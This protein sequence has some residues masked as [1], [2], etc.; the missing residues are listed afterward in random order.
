MGEGRTEDGLDLLWE[1]MIARALVR[2]DERGEG[3]LTAYC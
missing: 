2:G 1:S 3:R